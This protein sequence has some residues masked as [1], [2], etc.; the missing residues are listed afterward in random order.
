MESMW[1][2]QNTEESENRMGSNE[3]GNKRIEYGKDDEEEIIE[4][5]VRRHDPLRVCYN[6]EYSNENCTRMT[7]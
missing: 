6:L 4:C 5:T 1:K 3:H 7:F 2:T